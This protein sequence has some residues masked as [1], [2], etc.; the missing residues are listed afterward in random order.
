MIFVDRMMFGREVLE[1]FEGD[2]MRIV[3]IVMIR[4]LVELVLKVFHVSRMF[5]EISDGRFRLIEVD[6]SGMIVIVRV[7][8]RFQFVHRNRMIF[9]DRMMFDGEV[10][11]VIESNV[12][13]IVI[14]V[15]CSQ[16]VE[17]VREIFHVSRM[18]S[19]F[20]DG[21]FRFI[22]VDVACMVVVVLVEDCLKLFERNGILSLRHFEC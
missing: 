2:M 15:S 19:E 20:L 4:Q 1:V 8:N 11:E 14:A 18:G 22:K 12:M 16:L 21:R 10:L 3:I 7:E 13:G 17:F 9:V 6:A 5:A